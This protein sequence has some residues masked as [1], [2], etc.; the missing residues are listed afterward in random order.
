MGEFD[1]GF[2]DEGQPVNKI[3]TMYMTGHS[4]GYSRFYDGILYRNLNSARM[5][6]MA[7]HGNY[8]LEPVAHKCVILS[9][10]KTYIVDGPYKTATSVA[11]EKDSRE[12]ALAKLTPEEQRLL[13]LK[14]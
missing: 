8:Y 4:D 12:R 5:A 7:R 13:G 9:D 2:E 10:G 14:D 3:I 1:D 11:Q 6:G